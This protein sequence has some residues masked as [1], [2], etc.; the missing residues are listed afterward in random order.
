MHFRGNLEIWSKKIVERWFDLVGWILYY[1]LLGQ[2]L[3]NKNRFLKCR[4]SNLISLFSLELFTHEYSDADFVQ[5]SIGVGFRLTQ[6]IP[7][8]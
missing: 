2:L 8:T 3:D 5:L 6:T 1:F 4:I 7:Y